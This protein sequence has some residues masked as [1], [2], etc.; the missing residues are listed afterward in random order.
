MEIQITLAKWDSL[1]ESLERGANFIRKKEMEL[2]GLRRDLRKVI[3]GS[4]KERIL[5]VICREEEHLHRQAEIL[6]DLRIA[7]EK[8]ERMYEH[9]EQDLMDAC[10]IPQKRFQEKIHVTSLNGWGGIPV[11]LQ[12]R[13]E[14]NY[15]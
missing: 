12:E 2:Q 10:E 1:I 4:E 14:R 11:R 6:A 8:A 15:E 13:E 9:C 7:M 5:R 3:N